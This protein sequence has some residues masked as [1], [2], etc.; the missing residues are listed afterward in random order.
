MTEETDPPDRPEL[1]NRAR[2]PRVFLSY[3]HRDEPILEA[4]LPYLAT[5]EREGLVAVWSDRQIQG[6]ERWREAIDTALDAAT[7]AVLLIS[8]EFLASP[9]VRD[10][11][12]PRI[13]EQQLAGQMT[14]LPVFVS[15]STVTSDS[16][17]IRDAQGLERRIVLGELQGF[18][19]PD[20]TLSE[21]EL[22]ERQRCFVEL[23]NRI[24]ALAT[25]TRVETS[26]YVPSA[27]VQGPEHPRHERGTSGKKGQLPTAIGAAAAIVTITLGI[28][29]WRSLDFN[30]ALTQFE[31]GSQA[32]ITG[33]AAHGDKGIRVL[34]EGLDVTGEM[35]PARFPARALGIIKV[36]HEH[37]EAV[38]KY[39]LDLDVK[40]TENR[41]RIESAA[42]TL[43]ADQE[44]NLAVDPQRVQQ[45]ENLS[46]VAVCMN[47]LMESDSPDWPELAIRVRVLLRKSPVCDLG[48][49][50]TAPR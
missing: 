43:E 30:D 1:A 15:P 22:A 44:K 40:A 17:I 42:T 47:R 45:L 7:I 41:R 16:V 29:G 5:L 27:D 50:P 11:E 18:G 37:P 28:L 9:F 23:H 19:A 21:L 49:R 38:E 10:E 25:G 13:L 46:R 31:S 2:A 39:R 33:L 34:V 48:T 8:Q 14:I 4:L 24:R 20:M 35:Q 36:L 26:A 3:S 6:G 12:L 32:G